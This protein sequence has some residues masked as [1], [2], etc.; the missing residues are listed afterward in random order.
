MTFG[1]LL[2]TKDISLVGKLPGISQ[3]LFWGGCLRV[4]GIHCYYCSDDDDDVIN[5]GV[6]S[7]FHTRTQHLWRATGSLL[8]WGGQGSNPHTQMN[9]LGSTHPHLLSHLASPGKLYLKDH[10]FAISSCVTWNVSPQNLYTSHGQISLRD[11]VYSGW[12]YRIFG[13]YT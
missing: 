9:R 13:Y 4:T 10:C 2:D 3:H 7:L 5:E 8:P 12:C 11:P 6:F 1:R